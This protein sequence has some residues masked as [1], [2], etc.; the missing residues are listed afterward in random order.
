MDNILINVLEAMKLIALKRYTTGY[1][2]FLDEKDSYVFFKFS[3]KG[4]LKKLIKY[5][6]SY[7]VN[8]QHFM[9]RITRVFTY[10]FFLEKPVDLET[11]TIEELDRVHEH[12]SHY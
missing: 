10:S 8:F 2:G 1:T 3:R 4:Q 9:C 6:K 12:L 7:F 11:I 5:E